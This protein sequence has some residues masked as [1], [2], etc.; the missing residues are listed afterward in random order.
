[1]TELKLAFQVAIAVILA[2]GLGLALALLSFGP[3][4]PFPFSQCSDYQPNSAPG[5]CGPLAPILLVLAGCLLL[6]AVMSVFR[7]RSKKK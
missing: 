7:G 5:S 6:I 4:Q 2:V 1:V 3:S